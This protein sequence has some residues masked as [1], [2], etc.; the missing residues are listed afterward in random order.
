MKDIESP[1]ISENTKQGKAP[2]HLME[3]S[4]MSK[5]RLLKPKTENLTEFKKTNTTGTK[6][7]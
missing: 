1:R 3:G 2:L 5:L 6:E 7:E 4:H